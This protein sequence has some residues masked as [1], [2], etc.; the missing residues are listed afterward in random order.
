MSKQEKRAVAADDLYQIETIT[1]AE[2]SPDGL[3]V[4]YTQQRVDRK[5]E[6]KHSNLWIVPTDGSAKPRQFTFGDHSD[7]GP[8]WSPRGDS[9]AFMSNRKDEKQM[10]L[11]VIPLNGGEA[12]PMTDFKGSIGGYAWSPDS[13]R[14][15][16]SFR[17]KDAD[18]I[19][20]DEDPQKGKLGVVERHITEIKVREE[21]VGYL[22]KEEAHIWTV[23][24]ATGE[25]NQITDGEFSENS[26]VWS[27]DGS[28]I[29]FHSNRSPDRYL[30]PMGGEFYLV[31][32]EGGEMTKVDTHE[33]PKYGASFSPDGEHLVYAGLRIAPG[34]WY[35]NTV[36][37]VAP[38]PNDGTPAANICAKMDYD[39]SNCTGGDITN[40]YGMMPQFSA[41]GHDVYAQTSYHGGNQFMRIDG[42]SGEAIPV[43]DDGSVLGMLTLDDSNDFVSFFRGNHTDPGNL[44]VRNLRTDEEVQLTDIHADYLAEIEIGNIEEHWIKGSDDNDLHGWILTPADFDPKKKYPSIMCIHGGPQTQ[45]GRTFFHEFYLMAAQGYVVHFSNPR[46]GQGYGEAHAKAI[47]GNWGEADYADVMAWA[48][49]VASQ[50]YI[51]KD[52]M[53]ITGGSYGG[54]MTSTTIGKTDRFKAAI[55]LRMLSNWVSFHGTSD[56]NWSSIYLAGF[57]GGPWDN[58]D[59]YWRMSPMSLVGNVKTP[60]LVLH[61]GGD[62]R[63]PLEQGE[64]YFVALKKLGVDTELVI[65]PEEN[66]GLSRGG[67]TDRRVARLNHMLRWFDKYL[68]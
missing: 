11:Y 7:V 10:Q 19:E 6:K 63:T 55:V 39:W 12:R 1:G 40:P 57:E 35:Q 29:L 30:N 38:V 17:Q 28:Q 59:H 54:Y 15:A 22:P 5:T 65:F 36:I 34:H 33:G 67:R 18:A 14:F 23:D 58:L 37:F 43:I 9:I 31:S 26:P 13:A 42:E 61:S 21:N 47:L 49:F 48:D 4:I 8:A 68:K 32:A 64:Q 56:M 51:D 2:I 46:G 53:G 16:L 60:T 41:D 66:H 45:Y 24:V 62:L 50:P 27:P 52:R 44:W 20:R 25:A 3:Q